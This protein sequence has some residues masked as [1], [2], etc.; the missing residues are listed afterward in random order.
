VPGARALLVR[1]CASLGPAPDDPLSAT[2]RAQAVALAA[3][4]EGRGVDHLLSSPHLRARQSIQPFAPRHG[5]A[6]GVDD[7]LAERVLSV[8]NADRWREEIRASFADPDRVLPGA[9]S[10]R[11]ALARGLAVLD[12]AL[13]GPHRLVALVTH[14]QLMSLVLHAIDPAFGYA[15]WLSLSNPDVYSIDGPPGGPY[16]AKRLWR[17]PAK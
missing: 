13:G 10:A 4:L 15:G 16:T 7:R 14:G 1:H 5:L 3:W 17:P 11:A 6:V 8:E 9:E 2:G 12:A